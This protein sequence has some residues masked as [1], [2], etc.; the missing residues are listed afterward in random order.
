MAIRRDFCTV[1]LC[2]AVVLIGAG[3]AEAQAVR[4]TNAKVQASPAAAKRDEALKKLTEAQGE[5]KQAIKAL[6]DA[7]EK[8]LKAKSDEEK[9][10]ASEQVTAA[11]KRIETAQKSV[12]ERMQAAER[13]GRRRIVAPVN[14]AAS[15]IDTADDGLSPDD[16]VV[17]FLVFLPGELIVV[18]AAIT[19]DRKPFRMVREQ[20]IDN[21]LTY[22]D[23]DGDGKP[24]WE[25]GLHSPRFG[26]SRLR[27]LTDEQRNQYQKN[28]DANTDGI[29]DRDEAR[30]FLNG[31]TQTQAFT[32]TNAAG[33]SGGPVSLGADGRVYGPAR[34]GNVALLPL[35]DLDRNQIL[36]AEEIAA[37]GESL[38]RRDTDDND[39]LYPQEIEAIANRAV[40]GIQANPRS[41]PQANRAYALALNA[42][43]SA[44]YVHYLLKEHYANTDGDLTAE[45]LRQA[46]PVFESLDAD[47]NGKVEQAEVLRLRKVPAHLE[48]D[49]ELGKETVGV[50]LKS[51]S[52]GFETH[53]ADGGIVSLGWPGSRLKANATSTPD[54]RDYYS[55]IGSSYL[56]QFDANANGYLETTELAGNYKMLFDMWDLDEDG[57]VYGKEIIES[58]SQLALAQSTQVRASITYD[59]NALFPAV[60]ENGDQRL[61][62][63][64][65]RSASERLKPFD[66]NEDGQITVEEL[67]LNFSV[68]FAM[69][70]NFVQQ[71][72][73]VAA[74]QNNP[75]QKTDAPDWFTK[76]DRNGDGDVTIKEFLGDKEQFQKLDTNQDGFI[77]PKEAKAAGM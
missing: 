51:A 4:V 75:P 38:K 71:G 66:K 48:L 43:T 59:G 57:K 11:K 18:D 54:A 64:E 58:Y 3:I 41:R 33:I 68:N 55:Q 14:D 47:N 50:K 34:S 44:V 23:K 25:E 32:V 15:P 45:S 39:L 40:N 65:M 19:V 52:A 62:L 5:L 6:A 22:A 63:R 28:Y 56:K 37:A 20:V 42:K 10:K 29:V 70:Q 21:M 69:G 7:Q 27:Q 35:L 74:P 12:E 30:R 31:M 8:L 26:F 46:S 13:T 1:G 36:S 16:P 60:D 2:L 67:P 24:T 53:K 76:M 17:R 61:S 73:R 9:A 77:E 49:V 72:Q